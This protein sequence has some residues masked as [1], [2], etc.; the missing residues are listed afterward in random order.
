MHAAVLGRER[1]NCLWGL[2]LLNALLEVGYRLV[3][4]WASLAPVWHLVSRVI[5]LDLKAIYSKAEEMWQDLYEG[6]KRHDIWLEKIPAG[7]YLLIL[8][9][10]W[11]D[12]CIQ[13]KWN[14][15]D[16]LPLTILL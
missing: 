11:P 9:T 3:Y 10:A 7:K 8:L 12:M 4:R 13:N 16:L 5:P 14:C 15:G 2:Q 6:I 1:K